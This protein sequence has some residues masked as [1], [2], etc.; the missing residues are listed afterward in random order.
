MTQGRHYSIDI[1][2]TIEDT[3]HQAFDHMVL[4]MQTMMNQVAKGDHHRRENE[5]LRQANEKLREELRRALAGSAP[6][7]APTPMPPAAP[8]QQQPFVAP[9]RTP[10]PAAARPAPAATPSSMG[11][12]T[13]E[14][15]IHIH[16]TPVHSVAFDHNR[17][18]K[19]MLATASWD[20]SVKLYS[21][22]DE[23]SVVKTLGGPH[24]PPD[25]KM[26]GLYSV[27]FA[28][29]ADH[30]LGCTSCDATVYLWDHQKG[31]M[32]CQ[33]KGHSD[34]VNGLD[35][36]AQQQVMCTAS[37]DCKVIIWD[38][39]EGI[40]LRTLD[41][42]TKA[43]YGCKFL[44]M[45]NQYLVAT[46][47]FDQK[48]RIFDMRDKQVVGLLQLHTD[49]VIGVDHSVQKQLLATGSDDGLIGIWD[50]RSWKL[51]QMINTKEDGRDGNEVKRIGFSPDGCMLAAA[52]SSGKVLVYDVTVSPALQV[53]VLDG[54]A[55]C[56]FDV[57]WMRCERTG[58]DMLVS[59]SHDH[60]CRYWRRRV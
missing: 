46:C 2:V 26:G 60:T 27:A 30:I 18:D 37:D 11:G 29:T 43:V 59:A 42:H 51:Q 49:D 36:H 39:Q 17:V 35:F 24:A 25:S 12:F 31:T 47:C 15:S 41:K 53:A 54:H 50:A 8:Q 28:K 14:K 20:S 23:G 3:M 4:S 10:P 19:Q 1:N 56:V 7:V 22:A 52:C 57:S 32:L 34:E 5:Q 44:G 55:D 45:E 58:Y 16:E 13:F 21:L 40:T 9:E 48:T 33:L 38:F 6:M